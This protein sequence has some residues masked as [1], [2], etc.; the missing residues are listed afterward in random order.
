MLENILL[1]KTIGLPELLVKAAIKKI[2]VILV[3][4]SSRLKKNI[5]IYI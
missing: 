2:S 4:R 1:V 3:Q 5:Y